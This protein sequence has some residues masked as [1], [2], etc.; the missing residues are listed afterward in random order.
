MILVAHKTYQVDLR[1]TSG[2]FSITLDA[3]QAPKTVNSFL[4]LAC[5]DAYRAATFD[6][7]VPDRLL[8]VGGTSDPGYSL[9]PEG[10]STQPYG[11]GM[12]LMVDST[13]F[14]VLLD[15]LTLPP[16][17][18]ILGRVS[19]SLEAA[20]RLSHVRLTVQ[21]DA[22]EISLPVQPQHWTMQLLTRG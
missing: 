6:R 9:P 17:Y 3:N 12:V 4:F 13:H 15:R 1:T 19:S 2:M 21:P 8:E 11:R 5:T 14:L 20:D 7:I 22:Q 16:V 18:T 10:L